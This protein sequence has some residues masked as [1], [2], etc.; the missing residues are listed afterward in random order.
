[1]L[2]RPASNFP[3]LWH[4][5][6]WPSSP[7]AFASI[8]FPGRCLASQPT[9]SSGE[10]AVVNPQP[11]SCQVEANRATFAVFASIAASA[12]S[13]SF[14]SLRDI[15]GHCLCCC[16]RRRRHHRRLHRRRQHF[17]G[18]PRSR[19]QQACHHWW[20]KIRRRQL[21]HSRHCCRQAI[22]PSGASFSFCRRRRHCRRH[23]RF[24]GRPRCRRH[25]ICRHWWLEMPVSPVNQ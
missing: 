4:T 17:Q 18:R 23:Y 3:G 6:P 20:L 1:M 13:S 25:Q 22:F 11:A 2:F 14:P 10:F 8:F 19:Q 12:P 15:F 5:G 7:M 9:G 21:D 24:Q 16:H